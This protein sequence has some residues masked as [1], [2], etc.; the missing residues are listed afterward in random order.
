[1]RS[2]SRR[3]LSMVPL[4]ERLMRRTCVAPFRQPGLPSPCWEWTGAADRFGHGR[5]KFDGRNA[6]VRRAIFAARGVALSADEHVIALCRNAACVNDEHF[7]VGTVKEARVFGR[8]GLVGISEL[9]LAQRMIADGEATTQQL[10]ECWEISEALLIS[11]MTKCSWE[12]QAF[13]KA[14]QPNRRTPTAPIGFVSFDCVIA[15]RTSR[16]RTDRGGKWPLP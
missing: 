16:R 8:H 4:L 7:V 14:S 11:A 6:H 9:L 10:A 3:E 5:V 13:E 1:M 15:A 12:G 2:R